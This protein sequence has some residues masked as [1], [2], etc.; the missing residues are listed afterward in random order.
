MCIGVEVPV[1]FEPTN[2]GFANRCV[3]PLHHGTNLIFDFGFLISES[4]FNILYLSF[5]IKILNGK[6]NLKSEV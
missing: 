6:S 3:K 2:G 4:H 1:G 5:A